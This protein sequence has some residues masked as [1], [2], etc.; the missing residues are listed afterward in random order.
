[1]KKESDNPEYEKLEA[2]EKSVQRASDLT[3][4]L[5]IFSRKVK[6]K[7]R[8]MDLNQE[9]VQIVKMLDRMIPK[10]VSIEIKLAGDLKSV[11]ADPVQIEQIMMNLGV[12]ARDAM[13]DGGN[14]IFETEN[15]TLDSKFCKT[16][17][18]TTP[19]EYVLLSVSDTGHGME[20]DIQTHI[21]E[22]FFTT[23]EAG[24]GTGLGLAT[25]YGI[26]QS[27]RGHITC[28]SEPGQGT[29][30]R[31]YFPSVELKMQEPEVREVQLPVM[32]GSETI[33]LVDDEESI[34]KPG[35]EMLASVG[36]KVLTA[37]DGETAL[38]IFSK[39]HENIALI[40]LD[41]IMPGMGGRQCLEEIL[42]VNPQTQVIVTSGYSVDGSAKETIESK[43][44]GFVSKPYDGRE[45]LKFV[46]EVL[47]RN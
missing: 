29:T 17:L 10:M 31:I 7:L 46:R 38:E 35:E 22:P 19:G 47:D 33:L 1:M 41:L 18:G 45:L 8:P 14:L 40:I 2:I 26:V 23:K 5:L 43:A 34:R 12:N 11:S 3:K 16:H 42:K 44:K 37:P 39:Q 28:E 32:G 4:R 25:V 6:S 21:F 13:P 24:K 30:F 20:K 36:Y 27:H 9:V 15:I